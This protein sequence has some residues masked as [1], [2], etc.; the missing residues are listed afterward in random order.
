MMKWQFFDKLHF[1]IVFHVKSLFGK[2]LAIF[3]KNLANVAEVP[4]SV[5]V[6]RI[7]RGFGAIKGCRLF[8]I[9]GYW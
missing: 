7:A 9:S 2:H 3:A 6:P 4:G 1:Q 5:E 8:V